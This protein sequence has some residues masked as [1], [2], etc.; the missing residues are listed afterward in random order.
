MKSIRGRSKANPE[1]PP[2]L[3]YKQYIGKLTLSLKMVR[4]R[5]KADA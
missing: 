3:L 2:T 5:M 1:C 4:R